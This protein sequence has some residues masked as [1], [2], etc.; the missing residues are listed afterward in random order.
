VRKNI[1]NFLIGALIAAVP[2]SFFITTSIPQNKKHRNQYQQVN[3]KVIDLKEYYVSQET[4]SKTKKTQEFEDLFWSLKLTNNKAF[5][6]K[7]NN[8]P[9]SNILSNNQD[10]KTYLVS[11]VKLSSNQR[12]TTKHKPK[13]DPQ[14]ASHNSY[15]SQVPNNVIEIIEKYANFYG[16]DKNMMIYIANCESGFR[17][18]AV[19][20]PYA[21][22][23]Q[24]LT[25]TWV[26]NRKAMGLDPDPNLRYDLEETVKTAAFKMSR[27]GFSAWPVCQNKA[28]AYLA[29]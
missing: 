12:P 11:E 2:M 7:A 20:G 3:T 4:S 26:S 17:T 19:N 25:S 27:D 10:S 24:F 6:K 23:Y 29:N 14:R 1:F 28:Q 13:L 9:F 16:V 8:L 22:I 18:N 21:G 5:E 15:P